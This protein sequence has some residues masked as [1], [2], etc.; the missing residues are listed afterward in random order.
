MTIDWTPHPYQM[1]AI[2]DMLAKPGYG[3]FAE[4]GLGKTSTTLAA[5]SVLKENNAARAMLVVAPLRPMSIV[6]PGE[7]AKWTDFAGLK[8]VV[9]HGPK[10]AERLNEKADVYVINYEGLA[11]LESELATRKQMPFDVLCLDESTKIKNTQTLRYKTLKRLRDRFSRVWILTGT[12]APNGIENVF[13]QIFMLD[14]GERLGR[15]IT[16]FRR[17]YF[18][19]EKQFG[20]S[21]WHPR[22][23]TSER[24]QRKIADVTLALRVEDYLQMPRKIENFIK[25]EL[26][27]AA[28]KVYKSL[29]DDFYSEIGAGLVTAANAAAKGT[30]L[31]QIASGGVYGSSG[32]GMGIS[33]AQVS[34]SVHD[35]K[36]DALVDLIDEQEGQPLLVAVAFKHEVDA[37]RKATGL[38]LP[39]L[40][41]GVSAAESAKIVSQW[42]AGSIPV[43]LAH[44][45]SVAHGL[46]L[47]AGGN[48]VCWYS[49]TWNLEEFDQFNARVW[50]QGQTKPVTFHYIVAVD[51]IDGDVLD[52]LRHKARGQNALM[53]ALKEKRT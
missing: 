10:K 4:P 26:P 18:T 25:V 42:N 7:I 46:N 23:D 47:Q 28:R 53:N 13:G 39:Y 36:L 52:A 43:L 15:Y 19:E 11:W 32:G 21:L 3:L 40:G 33:A 22:K 24:V 20:Y 35:A 9:L 34:H 50:R 31:R 17:E 8:H 16:H 51:T 30:K 45:T 38:P 49:L 14:G 29:E 44:P 48:A 5:F 41:G 27:S 12:P 6:W 2:G 37:I 1:R